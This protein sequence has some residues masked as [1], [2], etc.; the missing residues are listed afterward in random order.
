MTVFTA[1][2]VLIPSS[3]TPYPPSQPRGLSTHVSSPSTSRGLLRRLNSLLVKEHLHHPEP[4]TTLAPVFSLA[5]LTPNHLL[6]LLEVI[7]ATRFDLSAE[8]ER[9][10]RGD[11][12]WQFVLDDDD[13][14]DDGAGI[15]DRLDE[16]KLHDERIL[17]FLI[18]GLQQALETRSLP[19]PD[20]ETMLDILLADIDSSHRF[21][22]SNS[23]R[24][25][26]RLIQHREHIIAWIV[27]GLFEIEDRLLDPL[28]TQ[29][30][31]YYTTVVDRG[32]DSSH[33]PPRTMMTSPLKQ[34]LTTYLPP[35]PSPRLET[36]PR[37]SIVGLLRRD[38]QARSTSP[39]PKSKRHSLETSPS[40]L[41]LVRPEMERY[42]RSRPSASIIGVKMA[43]KR[44]VS[45]SVGESDLDLSERTCDCETEGYRETG[46]GD[47]TEVEC[48]CCAHMDD[49]TETQDEPVDAVPIHRLSDRPLDASA[50]RP[51][52]HLTIPKESNAELFPPAR[53]VTT[54]L[55]RNSPTSSSSSS[56][57]DEYVVNLRRKRERE[58]VEKM[59]LRSCG[60][61]TDLECARGP[62]W[63]TGWSEKELQGV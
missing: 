55:N 23:T 7:L 43:R 19:E 13:D 41:M 63:V 45:D 29:L 40:S 2:Y 8:R 51:N 52:W 48:S 18:L 15:D 25:G 60:L 44:D 34:A 53:F 33:M 14:I 27:A 21:G 1:P 36:T 22:G 9:D 30:G 20:I 50:Q 4:R 38:K 6:G 39:S 32:E 17:R 42:D 12:S 16:H 31:H 26:V 62:S 46:E 3:S 58:E 5:E 28:D 47:Q 57:E 24:S 49:G 54:P 35:S 59:K 56:N 37:K 10:D 11:E 61:D